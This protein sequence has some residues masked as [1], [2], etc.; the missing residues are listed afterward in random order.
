MS[1]GKGSSWRSF[2]ALR[3]HIPPRSPASIGGGLL[4]APLCRSEKPQGYPV[5]PEMRK[6][7]QKRASSC[8]SSDEKVA[9]YSS[10][11]ALSGR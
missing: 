4:G 6:R 10:S 8:A 5:A 11:V 2:T 3:E 9:M 1:I 7:I